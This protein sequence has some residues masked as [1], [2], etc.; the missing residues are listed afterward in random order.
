MFGWY[1]RPHIGIHS[2]KHQTECIIV[3]HAP[4]PNSTITNCINGA[5]H[6]IPPHETKRWICPSKPVP[7]SMNML[8]P[9][10]TTASSLNQPLLPIILQAHKLCRNR[11]QRDRDTFGGSPKAIL[12]RGLASFGVSVDTKRMRKKSVETPRRYPIW[13]KIAE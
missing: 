12:C 8:Q 7:S 1:H 13:S 4:F 3:S 6:A 5:L 11:H 9:I 10:R 2:D